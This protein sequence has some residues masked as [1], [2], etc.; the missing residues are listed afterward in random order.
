[1]LQQAKIKKVNQTIQENDESHS[2]KLNE[3]SSK[4]N[5]KTQMLKGLKENYDKIKNNLNTNRTPIFEFLLEST[6]EQL[7][8]LTIEY[9]KTPDFLSKKFSCEN[10]NDAYIQQSLQLDLIDFQ[11][12]VNV[13]I[14]KVKPKIT[15]LIDLFQKAVNESIGNEYEVK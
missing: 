5:E 3:I 6:H 14:K 10:Y 8:K 13:Q 2:K 11:E 9:L 15:E 1:M 12:Y 4:L 7:Q